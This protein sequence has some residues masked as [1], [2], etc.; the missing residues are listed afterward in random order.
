MRIFTFLPMLALTVSIALAGDPTR[1]SIKLTLNGKPTE[2]K[3]DAITYG[4]N[5]ATTSV[6]FGYKAEML[7]GD[8]STLEAIKQICGG[9]GGSIVFRGSDVDRKLKFLEG[10]AQRYNAV[11]YVEI[12]QRR[13]PATA[14]ITVVKHGTSYKVS[15]SLQ[16]DVLKH[17]YVNQIAASAKAGNYATITSSFTRTY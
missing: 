1:A 15:T 7:T 13:L 10:I 3:T 8:N 5:P 17:P 4:F 6:Y 16:L 2:A 14:N 12:N 9:D 11:G